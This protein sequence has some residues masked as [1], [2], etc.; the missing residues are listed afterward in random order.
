MSMP[1]R[2]L[3]TDDHAIVRAGLRRII[4][5]SADMSVAGEAAD[6]IEA[7]HKIAECSPDVVLVD[8][9]MPGMSG[10]DLIGRIRAEHPHL[11]VLVLSM[12]KEAQFAV[13]ALKVG[14]AGYLTKDCAPE[15]LAQAIRRV[16]AGGKYITSAVADVLASE[17]IPATMELPH[18]LLSNREFQVFRMLASGKSINDIAHDLCLSPNTIST[19]KRRL[20]KKLGADNNASLV[21]YALKHQLV[22]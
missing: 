2:I 13:R 22:Q 3:I 21:R 1:I 5:T 11:P 14:A 8:I 19:H 9:S 6:G 4:E 10:I 7:L 17:V 18:K 16:V 15:Q 20:M 12:H